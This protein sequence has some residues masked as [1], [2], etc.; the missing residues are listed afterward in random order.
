MRRQLM[1]AALVAALA[2]ISGPA[3]AAYC[4]EPK[5]P[6]LLF[7]RKPTKPYCAATQNCSEWEVESYKSDVRRYY[8]ALEEYASEVDRFYKQAAEYVECM[9]KLD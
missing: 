8:S 3:Q 1:A 9:S 4:F 6:S 7:I 5:A 2:G